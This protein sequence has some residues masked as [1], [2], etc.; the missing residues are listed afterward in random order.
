M[1]SSPCRAASVKQDIVC[2][3]SAQ[4]VT[5]RRHLVH[6]SSPCLKI[7]QGRADFSVVKP[8]AFQG[9]LH[10][11]E[12]FQPLVLCLLKNMLGFLGQSMLV[13]DSACSK[14]LWSPRPLSLVTATTN[15]S[16][17]Q[18]HAFGPERTEEAPMAPRTTFGDH[19][20]LGRESE[21]P[22]LTS[23]LFYLSSY[24][25]SALFVNIYLTTYL[26]FVSCSPSFGLAH[27]TTIW[28]V[29]RLVLDL[30]KTYVFAF[31]KSTSPNIFHMLSFKL[32]T[33]VGEWTLLGAAA[34]SGC[35]QDNYFCLGSS[36]CTIILTFWSVFLLFYAKSQ[37]GI[38]I[39][40]L[41]VGK[42][43]INKDICERL[44]IDY[45]D[46]PNRQDRIENF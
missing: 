4:W 15:F 3:A 2:R 37:I 26:F 46:L 16:G 18:H 39:K 40:P 13:G 5:H 12:P 43:I 45:E 20:A 28:I 7:H 11:W 17:S 41:V 9:W 34:P 35:W 10:A 31:Y 21:F 14:C 22:R 1:S 32:G 8:C 38:G 36:V 23:H 27:L 44:K 6:D 42:C 25:F 33:S 30:N 19:E 29:H 24:L